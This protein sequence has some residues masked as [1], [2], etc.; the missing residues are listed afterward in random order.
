[1]N[2]LKVSFTYTRNFDE[3]EV[4]GRIERELIDLSTFLAA[5][6]GGVI[7]GYNIRFAGSGFEGVKA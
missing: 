2:L 5:R 3:L 7:E 6:G 4:D 1:M